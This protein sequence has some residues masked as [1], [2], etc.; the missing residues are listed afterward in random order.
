VRYCSD[1]GEDFLAR[2]IKEAVGSRSGIY[3]IISLPNNTSSH[4]IRNTHTIGDG[5]SADDS[6]KGIQ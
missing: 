2:L 5:L 1:S 4:T 6:F 3:R